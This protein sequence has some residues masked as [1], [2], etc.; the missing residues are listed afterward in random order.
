MMIT[1]TQNELVEAVMEWCDARSI[2]VPSHEQIQ[3]QTR[4]IP[5]TSQTAS[6]HH[7]SDNYT[8]NVQVRE[9]EM[10]KLGGPYR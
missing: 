10:P 3:F 5:G 8:F 4:P 6:T 2:P 7:S 1:M 9:I